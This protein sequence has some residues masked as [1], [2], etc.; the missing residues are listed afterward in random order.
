MSRLSCGQKAPVGHPDTLSVGLR[1][2]TAVSRCLRQ[3]RRPRCS[4]RLCLA[5]SA[6][7]CEFPL[8]AHPPHTPQALVQAHH[9]ASTIIVLADCAPF[10]Q[11]AARTLCKTPTPC[12]LACALASHVG[13][14]CAARCMGI[15]CRS[16]TRV[17]DRCAQ[18]AWDGAH[19]VCR[20]ASSGTRRSRASCSKLDLLACLQA[21]CTA[22]MS[23][24]SCG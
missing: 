9:S 16:D 8:A 23:R 24:S 14:L 1:A 10:L 15:W 22:R 18:A 3:R 12:S 17:L 6:P 2:L 11:P 21:P 20:S 7:A 19:S 5:A 4:V 13:G